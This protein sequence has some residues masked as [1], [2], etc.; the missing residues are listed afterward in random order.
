MNFLTSVTAFSFLASDIM[1]MIE[2]PTI[3]A[4]AN[5][6]KIF[7]CSGLDIPKPTATGKFVYCLTLSTFFLICG[8]KFFLDPVTPK[9]LTQ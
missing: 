7:M 5:L 1:S 6:D 4:S 8:D 2:L 9:T 3:A